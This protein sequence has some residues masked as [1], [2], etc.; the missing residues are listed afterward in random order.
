MQYLREAKRNGHLKLIEDSLQ[1]LDREA[2]QTVHKLVIDFEEA[3]YRRFTDRSTPDWLKEALD[4]AGHLE[5]EPR[6]EWAAPDRLPTLG[7]GKHCLNLEQVESVLRALQET[8]LPDRHPLLDAIKSE[9]DEQA[10]DAFAWRLFERWQEDGSDS[11]Q[12]WAM[13]AIGHFGGDQSAI[14]LTPL[15]RLW[16]GVSQ[17]PRAVLGLECLR[18]IGSNVA[19]IQLNGIA[20]KLKYQGLKKKAREFMEEIAERRGM[21][22]SELE[23]LIVPDLDLDDRGTR[24]FD[25]G[26]R[27]FQF[28]FKPDLKPAVRD[29]AGK[30]RADL[31]KPSSKDDPEKANGAIT[32][33]KRLK[34]NLREVLKTQI[35]RL[36]QAMVA[37]RRWN[38]DQF[39]EL[40]VRHPLMVN[41]VRILLWGA[42]DEQGGLVAAFRVT[43]EQEYTDINDEPYALSNV[44]TVG[45]VHPLSLSDKDASAW[46]EIFSDY[47]IVSPFPQ[48]GRATYVIEKSEATQWELTRFEGVEL[49]AVT[50]V[51]TLERLGWARGAAEEHGYY[52]EHSKGVL[53]GQRHGRN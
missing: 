43:D 12:K 9:V 6:P 2:A 40:L 20:Q 49:P 47:E 15:V 7:I 35:P 1:R 13:C 53:W 22:R 16:P 14:R 32:D 8:I 46:G 50:L 36:E 38:V 44:T 24:T 27:T 5:A 3:V 37:S 21:T 26:D 45:I 23:D 48:I 28:V 34:K 17:H 29:E 4:K 41:L 18:G 10:R 25:F 42:Y 51:G 11:K 31:P 39:E 30:V 19:L 33:W 52:H